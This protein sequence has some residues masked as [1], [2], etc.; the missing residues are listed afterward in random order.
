MKD[1]EREG[2]AGKEKYT[3]SKLNKNP[4]AANLVLS[5]PA[6][7]C[8]SS[9]PV[10]AFILELQRASRWAQETSSVSN[11]RHGQMYEGFQLA[12]YKQGNKSSLTCGSEHLSSGKEGFSIIPKI[13]HFLKSGGCHCP[14][15]YLRVRFSVY[16]SAR[17]DVAQTT[18]D[19][20]YCS[21]MIQYA[22]ACWGT[23]KTFR[24]LERSKT[25]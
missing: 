3:I 24:A 16:Q 5:Y 1:E 12:F 7:A 8:Y 15:N 20:S 4:D 2:E 10:L 11:I 14:M 17:E 13:N 19:N 6:Y 21:W 25:G 22:S 9:A 23:I 18:R